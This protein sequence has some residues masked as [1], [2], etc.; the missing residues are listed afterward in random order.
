MDQRR[1]KSFEEKQKDQQE[2]IEYRRLAQQYALEQMELERF[3]KLTKKEV[4]TMYD[5]AL[6][7]KRKVKQME[8][9]MDEV[10]N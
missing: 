4:K 10:N 3:K 1:S 5:K 9:Q 2:G 6:D 8:Q 7:D